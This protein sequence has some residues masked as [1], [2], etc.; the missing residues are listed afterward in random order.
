VPLDALLSRLDL[1]GELAAELREE[2]AEREELERRLEEATEE[3]AAFF[4]HSPLVLFVIDSRRRVRRMS[5]AAELFAGL[6]A[7]TA[8]G[9]PA[10]DVLRCIHR[11]E[12]PDGC[13]H[14]V[15][16]QACPLRQAVLETLQ[17]GAPQTR[18]EAVLASDAR[19]ERRVR[20]STMPTTDHGEPMALLCVEDLGEVHAVV[21]TAGDIIREI[22][23]GLFVYQYR[24]PASLTLQSANPAAECLTGLAAASCLGRELDTI[25]PEARSRGLLDALLAVARTGRPFETDT[26]ECRNGTFL[27]RAFVLPGE[28]VAV[29]L[30]ARSDALRQ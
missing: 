8:V 12:H 14:G 5:C 1:P 10:G 20:L 18:V 21:T 27:V 30:E 3:L 15:S 22:P 26:F 29:A 13:G 23:S 16:C 19:G 17:T 25:W 4:A 24:P 11:L 7:A 6:P 9:G 28:R 2:I